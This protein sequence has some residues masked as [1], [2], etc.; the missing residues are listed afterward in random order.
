MKN[1]D[2]YLTLDYYYIFMFEARLSQSG[3]LRKII[4]AVK[5]IINDANFECSS[6]GIYLQAI[7]QSHVSLVS[8]FLKP[9]NFEIFNC[10]KSITLGVN[11]SS[12][13]KILKCASNEDSVTISCKDSLDK[14]S[15][16]FESPSNDRVSEFQL[17]LIRINNEQLG[18]P[19]AEYP[20]KVSLTSNEYKRI[21]SDMSVIGDTIQIEI[22]KIG[23]KFEIEGDIGKGSITLRQI[24]QTE[25]MEDNKVIENKETIKMTFALRYL[26][27]FSK[28]SPLCDRVTLRLAREMPLQLEFKINQTGYIRYYLAPKIDNNF[29]S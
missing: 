4:E 7:D 12:L 16:V 1:I 5:D 25:D 28:A 18:I 20:N 3:Q 22:S 2:N 26:N 8:L 29:D 13:Y 19:E 11:L 21:C 9:E 10:E 24:L 17:K 27:I 14:L 23:T 6:S 15:L